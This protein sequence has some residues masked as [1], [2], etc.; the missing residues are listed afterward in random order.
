[1]T[2]RTCSVDGCTNPA[3]GRGLC[4]SHYC[5]WWR[6]GDPQGSGDR[7]APRPRTPVAERFWSKVD[8]STPDGCWPWKGT[9]H[10]FGYGQIWVDGRQRL[11]HR[12]VFELVYGYQ[13]DTVCHRCD[14]PPCVRPDH[15]FGGTQADN[16]RDMWEKGRGSAP[17]VRRPG[18][19]HGVT[20]YRKRGCRCEICRGA[21][22]AAKRRLYR[23]R[24]LAS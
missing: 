12:V 3:H 21:T 2:D 9:R 10:D 22:S 16:A 17:P 13:P 20:G 24:R 1:M 23:A 4:R 14:N 7:T 11:A 18:P 15:L 19:E 6:Y 8:F 5:R